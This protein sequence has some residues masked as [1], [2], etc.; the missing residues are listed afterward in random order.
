[1]KND[2]YSYINR[3]KYACFIKFIK[4]N[5]QLPQLFF[6]LKILVALD[7]VNS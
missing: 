6:L 2:N 1:M 4:K 5:S 7:A 3:Q